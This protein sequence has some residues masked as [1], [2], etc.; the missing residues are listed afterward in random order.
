VA[1]YLNIVQ[2]E[3]PEARGSWSRLVAKIGG[4]DPSRNGFGDWRRKALG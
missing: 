2:K 4:F 1:V 3:E